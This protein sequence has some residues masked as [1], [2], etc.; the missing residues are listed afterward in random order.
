[1]LRIEEAE[2]PSLIQWSC[3]AHTG[4]PEWS[5]TTMTFEIVKGTSNE[6]QLNFRHV[7]LTPKLECY[8]LQGGVGPLPEEPRRVRGPREE[9]AVRDAREGMTRRDMS[10]VSISASHRSSSG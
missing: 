6:C 7:G 9:D 1:M 8:D 3:M 2:R 10:I 4:L 5:G